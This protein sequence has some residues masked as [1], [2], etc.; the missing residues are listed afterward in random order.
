MNNTWLIIGIAHIGFLLWF[1]VGY[2]IGKIVMNKGKSKT[3]TSPILEEFFKPDFKTLIR[4]DTGEYAVY[5]NGHMYTSEIPTLLAQTATME[6][7]E[8][9]YEL[10][11]GKV[12]VILEKKDKIDWS[13]YEIIG[14][15]II[16]EVN[17][18]Q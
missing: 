11:L 10:D 13:Q 12:M 5:L 7:L 16:K 6:L 17:L 15:H 4:K 8:E 1:I 9:V 18:K 2:K 14:I 3:H